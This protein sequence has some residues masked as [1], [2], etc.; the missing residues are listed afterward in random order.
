MLLHSKSSRYI[1]LNEILAC[2]LVLVVVKH[3]PKLG[4]IQSWGRRKTT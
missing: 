1:F 4:E 2:Y 3:E